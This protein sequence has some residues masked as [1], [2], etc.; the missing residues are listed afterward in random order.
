MFAIG[1]AAGWTLDDSFMLRLDGG[2]WFSRRIARSEGDVDAQLI[3]GGLSALVRLARAGRLRA[4]VGAHGAVGVAHLSG[5]DYPEVSDGR[6]LLVRSGLLGLAQID[7][8]FWLAQVTT[9]LATPVVGYRAVLVTDDGAR[10]EF[11]SAPV[12]FV[13]TAG[14]GFGIP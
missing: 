10:E 11:R 6:A 14:L 5:H 1:L 12:L 9:E 3:D 4:F 2:Y 7:M 8:G 13:V